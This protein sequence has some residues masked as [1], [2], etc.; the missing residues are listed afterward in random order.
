MHKILLFSFVFWLRTKTHINEKTEN[1]LSRLLKFNAKLSSFGSVFV[2]ICCVCRF[3]WWA[4]DGRSFQNLFST[5]AVLSGVVV[6]ALH[7][8]RLRNTI[9]NTAYWR[10]SQLA[11]YGKSETP[12]CCQ[13]PSSSS[14]FADEEADKKKRNRQNE[15][16]RRFFF[17]TANCS[18]V[19][20][21]LNDCE[22]GSQ[23]TLTAPQL[24]KVNREHTSKLK[25]EIFP[26]EIRN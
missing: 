26:A 17:A 8:F 23:C 4:A 15:R 24:D 18:S 3:F 5:G 7:Y 11:S 12:L 21:S 13:L 16:H 1:P 25:T 20:L 14:S 22:Q 2:A 10:K 9:G 6:G 19:Q